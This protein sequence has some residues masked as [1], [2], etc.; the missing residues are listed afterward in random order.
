LTAVGGAGLEGFADPLS[1]A[2]GFGSAVH[3]IDQAQNR[4]APEDYGKPEYRRVFKRDLGSAVRIG[5]KRFLPGY[6]QASALS[7]A[8]RAAFELYR[9]PSCGG[10]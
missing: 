3:A 10:Q 6:L 4:T 8:V 2:Y 7:G 5:L 1:L 9:N